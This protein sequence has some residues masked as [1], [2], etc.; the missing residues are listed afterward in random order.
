LCWGTSTSGTCARPVPGGLRRVQAHPMQVPAGHVR[1][2]AMPRESVD[3]T[4]RTAALRTPRPS[5]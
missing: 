4:C 1:S 5:P 3:M 2:A